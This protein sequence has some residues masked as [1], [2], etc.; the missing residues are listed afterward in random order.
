MM[1]LRRTADG[2]E[3][4]VEHDDFPDDWAKRDEKYSKYSDEELEA[5]IRD[6]LK[7][8][9]EEIRNTIGMK[10]IRQA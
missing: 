9:T 8:A 2:F 5:I 3:Y 10:P 7:K 4:A 6:R 1:D